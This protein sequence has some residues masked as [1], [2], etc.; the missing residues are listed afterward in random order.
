LASI[1][2]ANVKEL[3]PDM[4]VTGS[5]QFRVTRNSNLFFDEEEIDDLLITLEGELPSRRYGDAVRLEIEENCPEDLATFLLD[6]FGLGTDD[7]YRVN[8]PVNLNRLLAIYDLVDRAE[9]KF[10]SF[11]P[12]LPR[13]LIPGVALFEPIR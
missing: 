4:N 12:G 5:Y 3:F 8:G 9:L 11:T 10:S 7:L 1:I 2:I 6:H 13:G